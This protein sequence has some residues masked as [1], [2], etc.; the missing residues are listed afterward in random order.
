MGLQTS[1]GDKRLE[2][3]VDLMMRVVTVLK[4][5]TSSIAGWVKLIEN[6]NSAQRACGNSIVKKL[7]GLEKKLIDVSTRIKR[8][9][10]LTSP[11]PDLEWQYKLESQPGVRIVNSPA[12]YINESGQIVG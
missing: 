1:K 10:K 12:A 6:A 7:E 4:T 2:A 5:E 11:I 8:N 9:A 3:A